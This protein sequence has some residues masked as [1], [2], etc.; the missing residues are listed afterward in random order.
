[1]ANQLSATR[2]ETLAA[3]DLWRSKNLQVKLGILAIGLGAMAQVQ[4]L[5]SAEATSALT[6]QPGLNTTQTNMAEVI[7]VACP[8]GTNQKDFQERCN[9]VVG[10][11]LSGNPTSQQESVNALQLVSPEQIPSQ[12]FGAT[13]TSFNAI[14]GRLAALRAGVRGFHVAGLTNSQALRLAGLSPYTETG[15]AAGDDSSEIWDRWGGFINGNYNTGDV[16]SSFNQL[17]YNFNGGSVTTGLD[18][19][20]THDLILGTAFTYTRTESDFDRNNGSLNSDAYTGAF[21]G[22]FYATDRLYFDGI[23]T[24]GGID[25]SSTRHIQYTVPKDTPQNINAQ[26]NPGGNQYS[27]N[28]GGGYNFAIE[29]WSLNPYAQVNYIKLEA[30]GFSE[31]NGNGWGMR[32]DEQTVESVTTML[33][34]QVSYALSKPWGVLLPSIRGEWYH[35][36]KDNSRNIAVRFLGDTTSGLG[37]NTVTESPDRN[38][39]IV[40]TGVSGTFAKGLT[41]FLNYDTLLGYRN[42][43]SHLFTVGARLEF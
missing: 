16:D 17:G 29:E 24:F 6:S 7:G 15:G 30:D 10:A 27:V 9:G 41:A 13:R 40:G 3:T 38:Y 39:F 8:N 18:Y 33:G 20:L 11:A 23:V 36:Y 31:R 35:Q 14:G 21:Y 12:G 28:L 5:T 4:A 1:M 2:K 19:R 34:G 42:I 26:A 43:D 25:Y 32:F 37:F 22:T